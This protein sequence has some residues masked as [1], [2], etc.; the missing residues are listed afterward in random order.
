[1]IRALTDNLSRYE[2]RFGQV[3]EAEPPASN[4]FKN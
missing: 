1:M 3:I 2:T 4:G